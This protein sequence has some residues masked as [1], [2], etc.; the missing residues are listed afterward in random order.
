MS[1]PESNPRE[2][3]WLMLHE[4]VGVVIMRGSGWR[5]LGFV[6]LAPFLAWLDPLTSSNHRLCHLNSISNLCSRTVNMWLSVQSPAF[7]HSPL[8]KQGQCDIWVFLF[9]KKEARLFCLL[10]VSCPHI[11]QGFK[12]NQDVSHPVNF[13]SGDEENVW[14]IRGYLSQEL[15]QVSQALRPQGKVHRSRLWSHALFRPRRARHAKN[16]N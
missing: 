10:W 6:C 16:K 9:F 8:T 3:L 15:I 7:S 13:G 11:Q 2:V 14:H 1:R 4:E 5:W 12:W